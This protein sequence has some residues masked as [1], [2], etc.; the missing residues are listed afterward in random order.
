MRL[1]RTRSLVI[2]IDAELHVN[3]CFYKDKYENRRDEQVRYFLTIT[4]QNL[5][6]IYIKQK[7]TFLMK[8]S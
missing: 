3:V 4:L 5:T 2:S 1:F 7:H 8:N 6:S